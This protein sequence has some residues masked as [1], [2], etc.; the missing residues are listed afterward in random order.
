MEKQY[1]TRNEISK[2]LQCPG[3]VVDYLY[4]S[5]RLPVFRESPGK[6]FPRLYNREAL[7]IIRKHLEKRSR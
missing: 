4:Y 7:A 3:Y 5:R 6:G 2:E 1:I